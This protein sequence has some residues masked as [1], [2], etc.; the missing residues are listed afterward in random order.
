MAG[1]FDKV[2]MNALRPR[3]TRREGLDSLV[4]VVDTRAA[5]NDNIVVSIESTPM[6]NHPAYAVSAVLCRNPCNLDASAHGS[7]SFPDADQADPG[8][9][10]FRRDGRVC[11]LKP[12]PIVFDDK[13]K[14]R[15]AGGQCDMDIIGS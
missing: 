2:M 5:V 15:V 6:I 7:H 10:A 8:L 14:I 3:A 11:R 13:N 4:T 1:P 12:D 9:P